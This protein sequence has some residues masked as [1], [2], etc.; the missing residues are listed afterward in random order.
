MTMKMM[1]MNGRYLKLL[2]EAEKAAPLLKLLLLLV[3]VVVVV[4]VAAVLIKYLNLY[5]YRPGQVLRVP[6]G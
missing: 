6:G 3:V 5:L 4:G 1:R 2:S